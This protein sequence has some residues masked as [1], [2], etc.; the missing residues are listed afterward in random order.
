MRANKQDKQF[1]VGQ[2]Q[3]GRFKMLGRAGSFVKGQGF[4]GS[5]GRRYE[6]IAKVEPFN[7]NKPEHAEF[8]V[9]ANYALRKQNAQ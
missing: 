1:I 6:N 7:S 2:S 3:D 9:F 4:I 5:D 8:L